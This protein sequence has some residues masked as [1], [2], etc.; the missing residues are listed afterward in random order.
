MIGAAKAEM[1]HTRGAYDTD[2]DGNVTGGIFYLT[3]P[4]AAGTQAKPIYSRLM[5]DFDEAI[6]YKVEN[7]W[8]YYTYTQAEN[9]GSELTNELIS[10]NPNVLFLDN[11]KSNKTGTENDTL[12]TFNQD[13]NPYIAGLMTSEKDIVWGFTNKHSN[14]NLY[15]FKL[16]HVMAGVKVKIA[17][18]MSTPLADQYNLERAE[19]YLTNI[20][21][22]PYSYSRLTG[23]VNLPANPSYDNLI[24]VNNL[25][26][27]GGDNV[28]EWQS[29]DE[30]EDDEG[31]YT[32]NPVYLTKEFILPPQTP[33][34]SDDNWPELVVRFP[35]PSPEEAETKPYK[36]FYGKLP[37]AMFTDYATTNYGLDLAFLREHILEIRTKIS[38]N[39]PQLYFLPVRVYN[40]VNW[41]PYTIV[42]KQEGI[43]SDTDLL[44]II[45]YYEQNNDRMLNR[46]GEFKN[47]KWMFNIF[48]NLKLQLSDIKGKMAPTGQQSPVAFNLNNRKVSIY[49][50]GE[51]L[52]TITSADAFYSLIVEGI[53]PQPDPGQHHAG[54]TQP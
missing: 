21:T 12:I 43:Y 41:G 49:S 34:P 33:T 30:E 15:N 32:G 54:D 31:N 11:V 24:L 6:K 23:N 26:E 5:V 45:S 17:I 25:N 36:E 27:P 14:S 35:N 29:I 42:G 28:L 18:D 44:S 37:R 51:L 46:F 4:K 20:V 22:V 1:L 52:Y 39:P 3:Y 16:H 7:E 13:F 8:R 40:W 50:G 47:G 9:G 48:N 2:D 38:Q 19:V 53:L 10:N